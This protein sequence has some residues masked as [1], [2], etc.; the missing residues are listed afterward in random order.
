[1]AI[2]ISKWKLSAKT[3]VRACT[4]SLTLVKPLTKKMPKLTSLRLASRRS[5]S[6]TCIPTVVRL[7]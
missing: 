6:A 4:I 2:T 7:A 5:T 1:M 3:T